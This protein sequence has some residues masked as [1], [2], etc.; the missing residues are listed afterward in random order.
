MQ[1]IAITK[2]LWEASLLHGPD[3]LA[4]SNDLQ[5]AVLD[6]KEVVASSHS[7]PTA[8]EG[9]S[10]ATA[11]RCNVYGYPLQPNHDTKTKDDS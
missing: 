2:P 1:L 11:V 10:Y 7:P 9:R 6:I 3:R 5:K 4:T 8:L